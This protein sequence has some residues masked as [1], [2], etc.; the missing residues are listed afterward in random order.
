M[1][2]LHIANFSLFKN[3]AVFYS[4]DR[5]ISNGLI[6][7]GH[8]VA[9]FSYRDLS[10]YSAPLKIKKLGIKKMHNAI[11]KTIDNMEPEL[12]LLG[13]TELIDEDIIKT[14][15]K[16]YPSIKLAMW[17][18]DW[19]KN[20]SSIKSKIEYLDVLFT[21]TSVKAVDKGLLKKNLTIA[22]I[23]NMCDSSIESYKAF[24]NSL[25][26]Q[27]L[28]FAGRLDKDR[29]SFLKRLKTSIKSNI[30]F[31]LFGTSKETLLLG[32]EFL[33]K[34]SKSKMSI[35]LSRDHNTSLYS[36]D[37]I[38]QLMANGTLVFS[39]NIPD[40]EKLFSDDELIVFD[41]INECKEKIEFYFSNDDLRK[42]I[43]Y[44]GWEKA[45]NSYNSTRVTKF[46]LETIFDEDY[47]EGYEWKSEIIRGC[48]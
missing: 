4:I 31:N 21:T 43:A 44:N 7:N 34:M 12:I 46:M 36:S 8:F 14:I 26:E 48:K 9:D 42:E 17:W 3:E 45:H 47:S 15:K 25:Y 19:L 28:F 29:E 38:I 30:R 16:K 33:K 32:N 6:R 10:K 20:L 1:R 18:V 13:H 40:I 35:N 41:N 24:E 11:F 5:K 23:P 39:K 22:Y 37:R 27:D 2:I